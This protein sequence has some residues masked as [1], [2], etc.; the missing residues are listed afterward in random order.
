MG[1]TAAAIRYYEECLRRDPN[2]IVA[3]EWLDR[4]KTPD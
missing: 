4:L 3:R 2:M 1:E